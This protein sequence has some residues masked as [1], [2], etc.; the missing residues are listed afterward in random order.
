MKVAMILA[1]GRGDRLRPLTDTLPKGLCIVKGKTLIEH[2]IIN[3][4]KAGFDKIVINHAY[5]GSQIRQFVGDG[6]KWG[7]EICYSPEPPGGLETGGG[8]VCALPLL[9]DQPFITVNSDIYTDY[10]FSQIKP[11][12]VHSL[13]LILVK[14]N[15]KLQHDGDFGIINGNQVINTNRD[16]TFPG[17]ACYHPRLFKQRPY[18]RYSVA[19]LIRQWVDEQKVT[20]DLH[21][22]VWF[23]IGT[24]ERLKAANESIL[25]P[26]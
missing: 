12:E 6:T 26:Q 24:L 5:L 11:E 2:H 21:H 7:I 20:A 23:D 9:G 18:G 3:L 10:D 13:H 19:P 17:I 14:K 15:P 22:G 8:I 25:Q 16:Y 4:V 1:A